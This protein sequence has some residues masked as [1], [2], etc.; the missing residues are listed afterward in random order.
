[1]TVPVF[2]NVLNRRARGA[3][4]TLLLLLGGCA[5]IGPHPARD[6]ASAESVLAA[7]EQ[8]AATNEAVTDPGQT[9]AAPLDA[10]LVDELLPQAQQDA[11]SLR[12][13][14]SVD[15]VDLEHFYR[16]LVADTGYSVVLHPGVEGRISLDLSNVT[17]AEVMGVMRDVYGLDSVIKGTVYQIYPDVQRS[18]IFQIDYLNVTRSGHSEMQVSAGK[19]TDAGQSGGGGGF[20]QGFGG[21]QNGGQGGGQGGVVGTMVNTDGLANF[22]LELQLTLE[23][24]VGV[25]PDGQV[26]VTPQVGLVMVRAV[27]DVLSTVRKYLTLVQSNLERQVI[28]EAK[29]LEVTLNEGF[30]AG[31]DWNTFGDASGGVFAPDGVNAGSEHSVAGELLFGRNTQFFNP[32]GS[33]FTL[34]AAV[35]DF[36]A[37]ISLL[38]TQGAVQVLS[39]PRIATVNNQKAVIKVGSDEFF[40]TDISTDTITAG[41]AI[42]TLNSPELTPFFSGIALDVTPQI[43]DKDEV[44]L[45]VH[46]TVSEVEEQL[47]V[48]SGDAV[49]LAASTIRESD[50]IVRAMSGQVVVIGGL[51][52]NSSTD[53]NANVPLLGRIPGLGHLFKQKV[54]A[55]TKSELVILLKPIVVNTQV[56]TDYL[57][58]SAER[59]ALLKNQLRS[60]H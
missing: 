53:D 15:N 11:S 25:D 3:L 19:V 58:S 40:V 41:N 60:S 18:E 7:L 47:K 45:H 51:M 31:I 43:S 50:S 2:V 57:K 48:I 36:D 12:F 34:S 6:V 46:P 1:M 56:Q 27:P 10:Q 22:W 38:E 52:Q 55:S 4:P 13:D 9:A 23:A 29:I 54:Q 5:S 26:V 39:S 28:L 37:A 14:L 44:V 32:T 8:G 33:S 30:Q 24:M 59:V 35:G 49:P 20:D 17:I 42:N 16:G 21:G